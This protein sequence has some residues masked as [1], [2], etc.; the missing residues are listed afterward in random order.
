MLMAC[1]VP[2]AWLSFPGSSLLSDEEPAL[3][4][5]VVCDSPFLSMIP[6]S[7]L[8]PTKTAVLHRYWTPEEP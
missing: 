6:F 4:A 3:E 8:S 1:A 5:F 2:R 7:S